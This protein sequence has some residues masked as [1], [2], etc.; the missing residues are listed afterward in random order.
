MSCLT[1]ENCYSLSLCI[2]WGCSI[3]FRGLN[4]SQFHPTNFLVT[5]SIVYGYIVSW[6]FSSIRLQ[7]IC[8]RSYRP[9]EISVIM[10][11]SILTLHKLTFYCGNDTK[12]TT[13]KPFLSAST[14]LNPLNHRIPSEMF[15]YPS[16]STFN[17]SIL[18][19]F[20]HLIENILVNSFSIR[21]NL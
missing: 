17:L 15:C 12:S 10:I 16:H 19:S 9:G 7:R 3:N 2:N 13:L 11:S 6:W 4:S 18:N 5:Y 1:P 8:E 14:G 21:S 20:I